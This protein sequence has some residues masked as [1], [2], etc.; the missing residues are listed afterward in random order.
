MAFSKASFL[1]KDAATAWV[2]LDGDEG[3]V[4]VKHLALPSSPITATKY[5]L[6]GM[7]HS[8]LS[9]LSMG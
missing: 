3:D 2:I 6:P 9:A 1:K 7:P 4:D 8:S 5:C